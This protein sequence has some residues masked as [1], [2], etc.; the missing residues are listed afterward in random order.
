MTRLSVGARL[1][2]LRGEPLLLAS[3]SP[4]RRGLLGMLG[5]R[6]E[7]CAS[8]V[9]E[10]NRSDLEPPEVYVERLARQ[11]AEAARAGTGIYAV[12]AADTIVVLGR[13]VLEKPVDRRDAG[14]LLALLSGRWH[15]VFTGLCLQRLA[16]GRTVCG[17]ERSRVLFSPLDPATIEV[18]LDTEEPLDKAG[19]YGIQG[20]GGVLVERVEGCYFNVMGLPLSRLR[21]LVFKLEGGS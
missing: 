10:G 20:Y 21:R 14:R 17:H 18:Y 4:R 13:E 6:H 9:S 7:A 11:K 15:E 3:A 1:L 8:D 5:V 12:L 16:D 2:G 19:A